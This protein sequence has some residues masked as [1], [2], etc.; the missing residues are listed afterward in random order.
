MKV[1]ADI[2]ELL[3]EGVPESHIA[4]QLHVD[5]GTVR[6]TR[7]ALGMP[8]P[9]RGPRSSYASIEDAFRKNTQSVDGGHLRWTGYMDG[10]FPMLCYRS[11]RIPAPKVAFRLHNGRE[12][13]GRLTRTCEV[14]GCV[15]GRCLAD[16]PMREANQ[17]ADAAYKAIFGRSP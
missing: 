12:P 16:R 10:T 15:A 8:A 3:R 11:Q 7:K 4:R 14:P 1:R 17:R 2:A 6:R 5:R 9:Q 13:V